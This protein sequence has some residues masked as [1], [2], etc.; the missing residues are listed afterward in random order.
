MP[1]ATLKRLEADDL[2]VGGILLTT[3]SGLNLELTWK[4]A[5]PVIDS[6][7][8]AKDLTA[9]FVDILLREH[10]GRDVGNVNWASVTA[11]VQRHLT[12]WSDKLR[13]SLYSG[14]GAGG[15]GEPRLH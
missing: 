11:A 6:L 12:D 7:A 10:E 2:R 3:P 1:S 14:V 15:V 5:S 4:Y 13:E 8:L 9:R